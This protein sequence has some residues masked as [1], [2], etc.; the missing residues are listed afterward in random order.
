M[1]ILNLEQHL[2][3]VPFDV[4]SHLTL[5]GTYF[6]FISFNIAISGLGS[7]ETCP[8]TL[9]YVGT[10]YF[11]IIQNHS[12]GSTPK[13]PCYRS[14]FSK[15]HTISITVGHKHY[16]V[17]LSLD[18]S[19]PWLWF[20]Q[21]YTLHRSP[22]ARPY[23]V[24]ITVFHKHYKVPLSSDLCLTWLW[25]IQKPKLYLSPFSTLH[26]VSIIAGHKN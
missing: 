10:Y 6:T 4:P 1:P 3:Q 19:F 18:F 20:I 2:E 9:G 21:K 8:P 24:S 7:L 11:I 25:V 15:P 16:M 22:F 17:S 5:V 26:T 14:P 13:N 23:T 12:Y